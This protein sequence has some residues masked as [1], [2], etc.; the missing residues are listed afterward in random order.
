MKTDVLIIGAGA[1]GLMAAKVLMDAGKKVTVLE[2]RDR[3]GGRIHTISDDVFKDAELGAE[4]IHGDLPVTLNLLK[5]AGIAHPTAAAEMWTH[6]NGT[7]SKD[8]VFVDGWN[9]LLKRLNKLEKDTTIETFLQKDFPEDD[10]QEMKASVRN[11]VFGYDTADPALASAF[12]LRREWQ[13]EEEGA[14]HRIGGGYAAMIKY[15]QEEIIKQGGDICLSSAVKNIAWQPGKVTATANEHEIY[16]AGQLLIAMPLGVL[17][18]ANGT[19][20]AVTFAPPVPEYTDAIQ[21][22]GFGAVIKILLQFDDLFWEDHQTET[23]AGRSLKK[24]GYLFSEEEIPTWWTQVPRRIPLLTGWIG[25]PAAA[26]KKNMPNEEIL[27]QSLC[28]LANIFS[29]TVDELKDKLTGHRIINWTSEP[30][31]LGSYAYDTVDAPDARK[32]LNTSVENTLFFAGEYL[33]DGT[34]MGTVEA[35]LTSGKDAAVR[36]L[37]MGI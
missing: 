15:L 35:A 32:L 27:Q 12:A 16:E 4:F 1:A 3:C 20:E 19:P 14:Q 2:A 6:K 24:M 34:A 22:M 36:I 29:R 37:G 10:Y 21:K 13:S 18:S 8:S 5:E 26:D 7:F 17:Q 9:L 11:F 25:G 30:F 23:L 28:S 31:T 33:Y